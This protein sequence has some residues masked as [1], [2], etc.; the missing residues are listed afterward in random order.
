MKPHDWTHEYRALVRA[1]AQELESDGCSGVPDFYLDCCYEH[2]IAYRTGCDVYGNPITRAEADRWFRISIQNHSILA[3]VK[4]G[5]LSPVSWW[6]WAGV[7]ILGGSSYNSR[8]L[9]AG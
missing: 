1:K 3:K 9:A 4:L 5:F 6:R 7:R 8:N 2:D